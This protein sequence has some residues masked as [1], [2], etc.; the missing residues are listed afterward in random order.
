MK[1]FFLADD[2]NVESAF[3]CMSGAPIPAH[4]LIPTLR[5]KEKVPFDLRLKRA[6]MGKDGIE[7]DD[8]IDKLKNMWIDF[9]PN[10][11][12]WPMMSSR[13][14]SSITDF[15]NPGK[16]KIVWMRVEL[17]SPN[18]S[19]TYFVP[20]FEEIPDV[21]DEDRSV[22]VSGTNHLVKPVFS[23]SKV[24]NYSLFCAPRRFWEIPSGLYVTEI[25]KGAIEDHG[26]TGVVFEEVSVV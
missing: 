6:T 5:G 14:K 10:S 21:I 18:E 2:P 12:A 13:M 7:F 26:I 22:F 8:D 1:V 20:R 9:Q 15:S 16:E 4:E 3:A 24:S 19:R 25:L 11:L 17:R 23:A